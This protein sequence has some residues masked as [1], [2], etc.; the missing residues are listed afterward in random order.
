LEIRRARTEDIASCRDIF[1]ESYSDL[2]RRFGFQDDDPGD[3]DW[4][5]P[6]LTHFLQ[7]DPTGTAMAVLDGEPAAFAS[8]IRRDDYWFLSFLFVHPSRQG[9]GVGRSLLDELSPSESGVVR[10]TVV[11]SF[12]PVSTGLYASAGMTPRAT[13]YWLS[14]V[15]TL[16]AMPTLPE[17]IHR[18]E[19]TDADL[20]AV[21][22]MDRTLLG[23][24][25]RPDHTWWRASGT[26]SWCYRRGSDLVG[27]AY[28]DDGYIGPA[29]ATD[30]R[31]LCAIVA[32]VIRTSD[33]PASSSINLSG[34]SG[35]V[36]RM[37]IDAG[38]RIDETARYRFMYCSNGDLLPSSYIHH[39]DWLP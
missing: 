20:A 39:A 10:A 35:E 21:D 11:E 33:D 23:F 1:E 22:A 27:Y 4:L 6:I 9:R 26:P 30:E 32:D 28:V 29:L 12:Q 19:L 15:R 7:T 17:D 36:F 34:H 14:G 37:L 38:A 2:H 18:A 31:M 13:K 8:S 5:R 3:P 16:G 25:R 24:E